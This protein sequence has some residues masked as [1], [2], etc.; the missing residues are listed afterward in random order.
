MT[1]LL[2]TH[3][4]LV[5]TLGVG[6]QLKLLIFGCLLHVY[7]SWVCVLVIVGIILTDR[8]VADTG[9]GFGSCGVVSQRDIVIM[10]DPVSP[11][12]VELSAW[13]ME[14]KG[15]YTVVE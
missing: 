14:M 6:T 10:T 3:G 15:G 9:R 12:P 11:L 4:E 8:N 13:L 5:G 7:W 2:E 1:V